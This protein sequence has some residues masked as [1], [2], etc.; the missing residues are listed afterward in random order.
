[1]IFSFCYIRNPSVTMCFFFSKEQKPIL[2]TIFFFTT[3]RKPVSDYEKPW[4]LLGFWN[5]RLFLK[6][7]IRANKKQ[8]SSPIVNL[9]SLL[10]KQKQVTLYQK[11]KNDTLKV[12]FY[13]T[14]KIINKIHCLTILFVFDICCYFINGKI[15][16]MA[17]GYSVFCI[18]R[19]S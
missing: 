18:S 14:Q 10:K 8:R 3:I 1:M 2:Q 16:R 9:A 4:Q 13:T 17:G 12:I 7:I 5:N 19:E 6:I 15:Y 11:L